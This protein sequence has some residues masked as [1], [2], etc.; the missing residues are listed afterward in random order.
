MKYKQYI[1]IGMGRFGQSVAKSLHNLGQDVL[2]VDSDEALIDSIAPYVTH[3]VKTNAM[4]ENSL[5]ALG[6]GNFDVAVVTMGTDIQSSILITMLCK[7]MGVK[8]VLAKAQNDLHRK[9]LERIGADKVVFPERDMGQRVAHNLV[10]SNVFD[11]VEITDDLSMLDIAATNDWIGKDL[12]GLNFRQKYGVNVI[13]IKKK[14]APLNASPYGGDVI[15]RGDVLFVVGGKDSI[16][17]F[18]S[19]CGL[20]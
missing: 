16:S 13:A 20:L 14:G 2:A 4:D 17:K 6:I 9:V 5:T 18:E 12:A 8:Y 19:K 1:V 10:A 11:Y 15:E 3:A 7:E